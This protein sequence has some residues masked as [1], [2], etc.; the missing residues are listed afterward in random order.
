MK[1]DTSSFLGS[2]VLYYPNIEFFDETW[3][4]NALCIWDKIYRIVPPSYIPKDSEDIK[5]AVDN[6]LIKNILLSQEDLSQAATLFENFWNNVPIIP[7]GVEGWEEI[8]VNLHIEKVDARIA[9]LLLSL[10]KTVNPD[11]WLKLSKEVANTYMLFL[12]DTISR[13]RQIPKLTDNS[14]MFSIMHY[15]SND[16]NLDE[17]C[18]SGTQNEATTSL[19][20]ETVM[21]S[22]LAYEKMDKILSFRDKSAEGRQ[23]FRN[24]ITSFCKELTTIEDSTYANELIT[25]FQSN[26]MSSNRKLIEL[27][28]RDFSEVVASV[29][30]IGIP[31]TLTAIGALTGMGT[32]FNF[33]HFCEAGLIGAAATLADV[34]KT[35][36]KNWQANESSYYLHILKEFNHSSRQAILNIPRC[37][38]ILEE[39]IND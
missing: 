2:N 39:F 13:R 17:F 36:R 1:I 10:S 8:D 31:T 3:V 19:V 6:G 28:G 18:Y 32:S 20:L 25:D 26:L 5:L 29:L 16:G 22:G 9:P 15:F 14:D 33:N 30:M 37:N 24:T 34:S 12:A 38:Q 11:G 21:P 4:K 23:L 27:I 7:A 35:R